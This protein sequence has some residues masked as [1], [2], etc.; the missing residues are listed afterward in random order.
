MPATLCAG[1][2]TRCRCSL[3]TGTKCSGRLR[4]RSRQVCRLAQSARVRARVGSWL[5]ADIVRRAVPGARDG[6][7]GR[8]HRGGSMVEPGSV[9]AKRICRSIRGAAIRARCTARCLSRPLTWI[10]LCR[11]VGIRRCS[12]IRRTGRV[13]ASAATH[14]R[15]RTKTAAL[16]V[17]SRMPSPDGPDDRLYVPVGVGGP[18]PS[19]GIAVDRTGVRFLRL[20]NQK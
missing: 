11:I 15:R 8:V 5:H 14:G 6:T 20:Q 4:R 16:V 19:A 10:T 1:D 18:N 9:R 12:G 7:Y 2:T 3:R 13:C 17:V